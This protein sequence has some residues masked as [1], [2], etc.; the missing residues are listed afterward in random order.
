M[1]ALLSKAALLDAFQESPE[2][3]AFALAFQAKAAES[4]T[5]L[6]K[7]ESLGAEFTLPQ[8]AVLYQ[9]LKGTPKSLNSAW[10][11]QVSDECKAIIKNAGFQAGWDGIVA[12]V[13]HE[14]QA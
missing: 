3:R 10:A 1:T 9:G 6:H 13:S 7:V 12:L 4:M 11:K 8:V 5:A 2:F 14:P